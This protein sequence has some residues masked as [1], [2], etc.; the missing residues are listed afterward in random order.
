MDDGRDISAHRIRTWLEKFGVFDEFI[1]QTERKNMSGSNLELIAQCYKTVN[2]E[3]LDEN[4]IWSKAEN[5][6]GGEVVEGRYALFSE[7]FTSIHQVFEPWSTVVDEMFDGGDNQTVIALGR[8]VGKA[9]VTGKDV[10]APFVHIWRVQEG[11]I[12]FAI[13]YR[14]TSGLAK[15]QGLI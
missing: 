12:V 14:D 8:C 3:L 6:L 4:I 9:L 5:F 10:S 15:A 2:L 7:V 1:I 11:K 13:Q